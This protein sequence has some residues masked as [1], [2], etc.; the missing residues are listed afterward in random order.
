MA[1]DLSASIYIATSLDGFIAR[2][3]GSLDWL[4]APTAQ[5]DPD[6]DLGDL[7]FA[8]FMAG[9]DVLVMGRSTYDIVLGFGEWAY[10]D[11]P[12]AVATHR[13]IEPPPSAPDAEVHAVSGTATEIAVE[14]AA[15]GHRQ[16]YVDGGSLI[17]QF[18]AAGLVDRLVLTRIPVLIG[19]GIALFGELP[20]DVRL[21]HEGTESW[22]NGLVQ[23][24]YRVVDP[25]A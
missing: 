17:R 11:T 1:D 14:L 20:H 6:L 23:S 3:D 4:N 8:D 7:G 2:A 9:V 12:V 10:G 21:R 5:Y 22:S 18:L 16:A 19:S 15:K 13:S 24:T 25:E